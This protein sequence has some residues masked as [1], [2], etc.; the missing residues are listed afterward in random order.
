L[1]RELTRILSAPDLSALLAGDGSRPFVE[2][3]TAFGAFLKSEIAKWTRV[4]REAGITA[5]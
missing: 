5:G 3:P 2:S 4:V 1:H